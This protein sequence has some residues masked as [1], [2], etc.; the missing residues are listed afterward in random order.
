[1]LLAGYFGNEV[2]DLVE[3]VISVERVEITADLL[4]ERSQR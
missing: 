3:L 2:D 4:P 1:M